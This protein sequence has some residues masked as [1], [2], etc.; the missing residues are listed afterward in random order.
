MRAIGSLSFGDL[1]SGVALLIPLGFLVKDWVE[2]FSVITNCAQL[3]IYLTSVSH[4]SPNRSIDMVY[5]SP[6]LRWS[7]ILRGT[8][9]KDALSYNGSDGAH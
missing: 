4:K 1:S 2:T 9:P 5:V 7:I 8:R 3:S 6:L